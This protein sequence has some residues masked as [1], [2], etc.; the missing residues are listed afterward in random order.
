MPAAHVPRK[1][2]HTHD[3]FGGG[4]HG[5][6]WESGP[7]LLEADPRRDVG[8]FSVRIEELL[9]AIKAVDV[10]SSLVPKLTLLPGTV[11]SALV[12]GEPDEKRGDEGPAWEV[13]RQIAREDLPPAA[14]QVKV[15]TATVST[16]WCRLEGTRGQSPRPS[17]SGRQL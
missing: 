10:V 1:K 17:Y 14:S 16:V 2:T 13:G 12:N 5:A 4:Q 15:A 11:L 7:G 6:G 3:G 9:E 8:V